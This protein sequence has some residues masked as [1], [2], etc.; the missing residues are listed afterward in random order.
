MSKE[1]YLE[2]ININDFIEKTAPITQETSKIQIASAL[3]QEKLRNLRIEND[4]KEEN[5]IIRRFLIFF[6]SALSTGWLL[7]T[8]Y[9]VRHIAK[10]YHYL[11]E[12]VAVAFITSA[13][14]TVVGLWAI[15]LK[16]FFNNKPK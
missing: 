2:P 16:Y 13:L 7:F 1:N 8:G 12:S 5:K 6:L 14:A 9:E 10:Q 11:P 4:I 15:G 3:E